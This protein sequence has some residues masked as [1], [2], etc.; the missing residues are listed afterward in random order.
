MLSPS[1][2]IL[3]T[4]I[5]SRVKKDRRDEAKKL[6]NEGFSLEKKGNLSKEYLLSMKSKYIDFAKPESVPE[7]TKAIDDYISSL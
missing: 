2:M 6:I 4:Y 5:I 7:L 1:Q 3:Y